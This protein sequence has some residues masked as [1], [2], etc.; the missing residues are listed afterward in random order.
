MPSERWGI[1]A[2]M[3]HKLGII[4]FSYLMGLICATFF[5]A[6]FVFVVSAVLLAIALIILFLK[7]E[8][9]AVVF[10]T[11]FLAVSVH[12][13]YTVLVY[14][15]VIAFD[16]E[17]VKIEGRVSEI[18]HYSNDTASYIINT[19]IN[20]INTSISLF[21]TDTDCYVGDI[22]SFNGKLTMLTDNADF[23][24]RSYYKTKGIFLKATA[25]SG[26]EI[27]HDN[28]FNIKALIIRYS[29]Y[30]GERIKVYLPG[31]EGDLLK[32]MFL[33]EKSGLS[34]SLSKN[35]KRSGI[36]HFTAVSGMHLTII[37]HILMLLI[38]LSPLR[39]HRILKF[40]TLAL[41]IIGFIVFFRMS[42]SVIR[43]GIM[44]I[45]YYG[46]EPFMR[47]GSTLNSMGLATLAITLFNPYAC[48]DVGL[49][50]SLAG[51]FGIGIVS[52][53]FCR[54]LRPDRF[55]S[56]KMAVIGST[57]ATMCTFPLSCAFF[58]GFSIIGILMN[59]LL[60]PLFFPALVCVAL[61]VFFFASGT[62]LMFAAGLC[63]KAM[64]IMI[65]F[66]GSLKYSYIS[67]DYEFIGIFCLA[68]AVFIAVI[69]LCFKSPERT[70]MSVGLSVC[71]LVGSITVMKLYDSD[72]TKLTMYSDGDDACIIVAEGANVCIVA[73]DDSPD[74]LEYINDFLQGEFLD[75]IS[76]LKLMESTHNNVPAFE[77]IP[78]NVFSPPDVYDKQYSL[79]ERLN[80]YC[81][82]NHSTVDING[83]SLTISPAAEPVDD[84]ICVI[85][86]YKKNIPILSGMVYC[87]NRRV[88]SEDIII[89]N[90]YYE[91]AEYFVSENGFLQKMKM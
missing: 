80:L 70:A 44:L 12:G 31:D 87:T 60:Y 69:Y 75:E 6:P 28:S 38:S 78:C 13:I 8:T 42:V 22:I 10:F 63:A 5:E 2:I 36:S 34:D 40:I 47:K 81:Y 73:S 41:L 74:I 33:G 85:Y 76:V 19:N 23:E 82:E 17:T 32:A 77:E 24:E 4:G 57:C 91:T 66:F 11:A 26:I 54:R 59:T 46:A 1:I 71:V 68:A 35:I 65:N 51:T 16:G 15:P 62:G 58:G 83:V 39:N 18:R 49:L 9:A 27:T 3:K 20:G 56:L 55:K 88:E 48:L 7:K 53:F 43:A 37:S 52:P 14:E 61:F 25:S 64:I 21:S 50:L 86:G 67:L 29:D 90:L 45:V 89:T 79:G 30:I 72:K 84:S